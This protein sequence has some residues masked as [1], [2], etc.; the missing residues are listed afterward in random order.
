[1]I[2][3]YR[4]LDE[5]GLGARMTLQ[6]HDELM[7]EAP[8]GELEALGTLVRDCMMGAAA[9]AVPMKVDM[10]IVNNWGEAKQ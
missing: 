8:P 2:D 9:L 5:R 6:I 3:V 4:M 10:S 7:F 1:M